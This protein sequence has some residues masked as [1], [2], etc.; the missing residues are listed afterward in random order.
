V[1]DTFPCLGFG[2]R[3]QDL[4][5][6]SALEIGGGNQSL[7]DGVRLDLELLEER[8]FAGGVVYLRYRTKA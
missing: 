2:N 4:E 1:A 7:P 5:I 8:R 6:L 3:D